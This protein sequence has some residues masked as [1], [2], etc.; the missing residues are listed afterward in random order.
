MKI[1]RNKVWFRFNGH[2]SFC[3]KLLID[4][5]GKNMQIDHMLPLQRNIKNKHKIL[6]GTYKPCEN[7][8]NETI[9]NLFPACPSCN[10]LKGSLPLES[11]RQLVKDTVPNLLKYNTNFRRAL[12][13]GMIKIQIE[14]DGIFYF[15]K[16]VK[17]QD[18]EK[19]SKKYG[20]N[21]KNSY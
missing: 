17:P 9:D 18:V 12:R 6:W 7:P 20:I 4:S 2:C 13:F 1:D 8:E 19:Q 14:W 3:G 11:Y 10:N 16:Y 21:M 5:S 15:E